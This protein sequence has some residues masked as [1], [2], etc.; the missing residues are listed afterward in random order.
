M[1]NFFS[2]SSNLNNWLEHARV[3]ATNENQT[4]GGLNRETF[5]QRFSLVIPSFHG[6]LRMPHFAT[7]AILVFS[8]KLDLMFYLATDKR[9]FIKVDIPRTVLSRKQ[10]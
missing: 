5:S 10:R 9:A 3:I 6:V 7:V 4:G 8:Q 1:F 2:P